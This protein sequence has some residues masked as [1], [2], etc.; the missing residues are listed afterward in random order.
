MLRSLS[1]AEIVSWERK[2][3]IPSAS[4]AEMEFKFL[5]IVGYSE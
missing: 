4:R 1:E 2:R 5:A 3:R